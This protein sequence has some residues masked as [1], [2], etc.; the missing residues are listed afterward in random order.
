MGCGRGQTGVIDPDRFGL[1]AEAFMVAN[2][3]I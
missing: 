2:R 3:V 1:L